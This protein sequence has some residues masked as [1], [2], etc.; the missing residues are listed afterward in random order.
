PY[1]IGH[2]LQSWRRA[3]ISQRKAQHVEELYAVFE[4]RL[5]IVLNEEVTVDARDPKAMLLVEGKLVAKRAGAHHD[6]LRSG[7]AKEINDPFQDRGAMAEFLAGG[8]YGDVH[9]LM[10]APTQRPDDTCA[11]HRPVA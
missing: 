2:A 3:S 8:L 6:L 4:N 1:A 10:C 9:Q 7:F 11:N 5:G